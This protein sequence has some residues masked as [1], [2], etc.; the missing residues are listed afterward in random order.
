MSNEILLILSLLFIYGTVI[1]SFYLFG[2]AGLYCWTA[3][4]T[5]I[6]NIEV[7]ILID[8]FGMEQTL[9]NILFASTFLVTDIL[10]EVYGKE[11]A[12]KATNIGI[13][14]SIVFIILSQ[15]WLLY[16]PNQNDFIFGSIKEVFSNTPRM[17]IVSIL[18]Y[19]IC[20]K[21]DVW[22]Y[23]KVWAFTDKL[24]N[25]KKKY[26]WIRN[27]LSTLISQVINTILFTFGAFW[28]SYDFMTLISISLASYI[29]FIITSLLDTPFVYLAR[30]IYERKVGNK[31]EG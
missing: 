21:F 18:V 31:I 4:A 15:S 16:T 11:K 7:L 8:A 26:L 22:I 12:K 3:I 17:M 14:V 19:V 20:Q 9:G 30:Y 1:L 5:I 2:K 23:H 29:I 10:S 13:Y 28:G 25:D 27:N 6:A 24:A